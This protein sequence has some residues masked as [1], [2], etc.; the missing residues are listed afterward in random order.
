MLYV[1]VREIDGGA[2][3]D[4]VLFVAFEE[5]QSYYGRMLR[6]CDND[7]DEFGDGDPTIVSCCWLYMANTDDP[8]IARAMALNGRAALITLGSE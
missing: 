8:D 6:I 4:D 3:H 2:R 7:P 5:A 1:V